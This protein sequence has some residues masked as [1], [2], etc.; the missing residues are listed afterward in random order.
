MLLFVLF[1]I[2]FFYI[3]IIFSFLQMTKKMEFTSIFK[4]FNINQYYVD[5]SIFYFIIID[6]YYVDVAFLS[7]ILEHVL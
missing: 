1:C 2:L 6:E 7:M 4:K 3:N 5:Y